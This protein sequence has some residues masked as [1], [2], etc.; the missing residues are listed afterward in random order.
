[1]NKI[2]FVLI[3][4]LLIVTSL[5]SQNYQPHSPLV[6]EKNSIKKN[7]MSRKISAER[8]LF[9]PLDIDELKIQIK[10]NNNAID[11]RISGLKNKMT[12]IFMD[13]QELLKLVDI[14]KM[15]EQ[16]TVK[17]K[18]RK[19]IKEQIQQDLRSIVYKGLYLVVLKNIDPWFSKEKLAQQA[20][21]LLA[22]TAI[23]G[24]NGVFISSLTI[25]KDN[26]LLKD[27]IK[28][29]IS[30]EMSVEKQYISKIIDNRSKFVYLIKVNVAPLKKS[31]TPG[32]SATQKSSK[33]I[34]LNLL[35]DYGYE[36][37][38][39]TAGIPSNEIKNI[40][41]EAA[42]SRD[43]ISGSNNTSNRRQQ[44]IIRMGNANLTR[45]DEDI[46]QLQRSLT[47]RSAYLQQTIEEK[48]NVSYNADRIKNSID[49]ALK[50]FD[51]RLDELKNKLIAAKEGE[52]ISRYNVN[53]T[54]EGKPEQDIAQTGIAIYKQL[55]SSYSKVEQ[56]IRES[57]VVNNMLVSDKTGSGQDIFREVEKIWLY[58]VAGDMDNF[59]LTVVAKFKITDIKHRG[60]AV[61]RNR[62]SDTFPDM[63]YVTG[64][65]FM[66]GSNKYDYEKPIHKVYV[67]DFY[68]DKYEVSNGQYCKFLNE[69]GNQK[70]GAA[71][72]DI[73]SKYC[74]IVKQS[75]SYVPVSDYANHPVIEVSWYGARAYANWSGKR[76][77]TE[78]EWEYAVRG[79]SKSKG[80]KYSGSNNVGDV[81][82]YAGN[83]GSK[84]HP[85]GTKQSNELGL[86][87]MSGNVWE[88]CA[89]WYGNNYYDKS[90]YENP[91]GP[92]SGD[93]RVLRGGSWI[94][95]DC[96]VRCAYRGYCDP[97]GSDYS[98]GFRCV[99]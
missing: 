32:K 74:K 31:L 99:R 67:K 50:Y 41:F 62:V 27:Q 97:S 68:I 43:V 36:A 30:G 38:L 88:W 83:S 54:V 29:N 57:E 20:E 89:D 85:V 86:Y 90:P 12:N 14:K 51:D 78:A 79:G 58:P 40:D 75:G 34:V 26:S 96:N 1:M 53:V 84:T 22:P 73:K 21:K 8:K 10:K 39:Q 80:Y 91:T 47:N 87:D 60:T 6:F 70:E 37:K 95:N 56:F 16:I 13:K 44:Q 64:G 81:A 55:K 33:N 98:I 46:K 25:V 9:N 15:Q 49:S 23:E 35:D 65:S 48:T 82:W 24:L 19:D 28:A 17:Q 94:S 66:M 71:W 4:L 7:T 69:K 92:S 61:T 3:S 52:L 5:F 2:I 59:L 77:P 11:N 72:L 18:S 42:S 76:L 45:I 93:Y 63:V